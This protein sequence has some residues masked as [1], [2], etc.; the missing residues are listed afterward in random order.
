M[1][2]TLTKILLITALILTAAACS[3]TSRLADGEVLYTGVKKVQYNELDSVKIESSVKDQIFSSINVKPNNPLYSPYY[4]S[5][6]PIGLWVYNHWDEKSTGIKG[7]LYK[8]LVARPVLISRVRPATRV[9]M[10]DQLLHD[11]GYFDS[12]SSYS[13]DYSKHNPKKAKIIY[14]V[15]VKSPYTLGKISYLTEES[16]LDHLIDS[17]A[18]IDPYLKTGS[19][20]CTDSL[21]SVRISITNELRNRAGAKPCTANG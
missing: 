3:T 14:E 7:W 4:R 15:D 16:T 19:R 1:I 2:K 18:M 13:L 17:A 20:Y 11:N 8:K 5:P 9:N 12:K 10:I 21:N 6:F